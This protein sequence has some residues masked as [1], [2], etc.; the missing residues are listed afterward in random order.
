MILYNLN[1]LNEAWRTSNEPI[2]KYIIN[3]DF[4]PDTV[5]TKMDIT[6]D[7]KTGKPVG[8][9]IFQSGGVRNRNGRIYAT[10][11][12][13]REIHCT[14]TL[15]LLRTK[16]LFCEA[17]HPIDT[18]LQRQST[19]DWRNSN[20]KILTLETVG[21]NIEGLFT[22]SNTQLGKAFAED[23]LEGVIPAFSLRALGS[24]RQTRL[25]AQVTDLRLITYD[26]VIYPSHSNAYMTELL[27]E[28]ASLIPTKTEFYTKTVTESGIVAIIDSTGNR[29]L[30]AEPLK[31][32]K[33][34]EDFIKNNSNNLKYI[35]DYFG[36]TLENV[37]ITPNGAK[38]SL[39]EA[40][41]NNKIEVA[42]ENYIHCELLNYVDTLKNIIE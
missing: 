31:E 14:R 12:L 29:L 18:S 10:E 5:P 34:I 15:E 20:C 3:E 27:G 21:N 22:P 19:I 41:T 39:A 42:L 9:A 13:D 4:N 32:A 37:I 6:K 38:V 26:Q 28:S 8:R 11:D 30:P 7:P 24:I 33:Q 1:V 36:T 25:G 35:N 17:G 2:G 40:G 23:L 16:N